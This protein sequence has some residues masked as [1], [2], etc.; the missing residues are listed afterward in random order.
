MFFPP[1]DG[2][3]MTSPVHSSSTESIDIKYVA[4]LA[5]MH[6]SEDEAQ[7]FQAPLEHILEH[8]RKLGE[9][10]VDGVEPTAHAATVTN[11]FRRDEVQPSL[12]H[13]EVMANAPQER[14][15]LFIV[16]KILE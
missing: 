6:L 4:N 11:V 12:P 5:R 16:P 13:A 15:G 9:L 2:K 8:V 10:N 3:I 14:Q 1:M 7:R